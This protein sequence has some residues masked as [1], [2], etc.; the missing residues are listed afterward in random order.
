MWGWLRR[1]L[2]EGVRQ[3]HGDLV[4]EVGEEREGVPR[5]PDGLREKS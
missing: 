3:S 4:A 2:G 1:V 5:S